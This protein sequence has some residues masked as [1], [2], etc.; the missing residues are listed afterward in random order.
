MIVFGSRFEHKAIPLCYYLGSESMNVRD[1]TIDGMSLSQSAESGALA[2]LAT[3]LLGGVDANQP[4]D[5]TTRETILHYAG[6]GGYD[7][8]VKFLLDNGASVNVQDSS[9]QTPLMWA[10]QR[11][12]IKAAEVLLAHGADMNI[13]CNYGKSCY[14]YAAHSPMLLY[15]LIHT[16]KSSLS[17]DHIEQQGIL[18]Y[19]CSKPGARFAALFLLEEL[20]ADPNYK[21]KNGTTALHIAA[22]TGDLDLLKALV[23]KG[24]DP[25]IVDDNGVVPAS[26]K[27]C[28]SHLRA[29][30]NS[31]KTAVSSTNRSR[32]GVNKEGLAIP[33]YSN[34][35][36]IKGTEVKHC[37]LAFLLP[38]II[39]MI[40]TQLPT[41]LGIL[42]MLITGVI[43]G[44]ASNFAMMQ[45]S[46]SMIVVGWVTGAFCFSTIPM[47]CIVFPAYLKAN[48]ESKL[49]ILFSFVTLLLFINYFYAAFTD[50]GC[51]QSTLVHRRG[52][53]EAMNSATKQEY[54]YTAMVRKP[55][56]SKHCSKT[57]QCVYR[58]DHYCLWIGNTV[59][60][61]NHRA[62]VWFCI[63][64]FFSHA[65]VSYITIYYYIYLAPAGAAPSFTIHEYLEKFC[66]VFDFIFGPVTTVVTFYLIIYN[67]LLFMF[68]S[69]VLG[70]QLWFILRNVTSNEVWF[71]DRYKWMMK[72][73][74]RAYSYYDLG[75]WKNLL[76]FFWTGDL[77]KEEYD[78]PP[79]SPYLNKNMDIYAGFQKQFHN[80]NVMQT[81]ETNVLY[82]QT[83]LSDQ[84]VAV[85]RQT[86]AV[87][88]LPY[89]KQQELSAV[90]VI[91]SQLIQGR[92]PQ[93]P[94]EIPE[95]RRGGVMKQAQDMTV[96][97]KQK[98]KD[99]QAQQQAE[100]AVS[101]LASAVFSKTD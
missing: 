42:S 51:V 41:V 29:F 26:Q 83:Y 3:F 94:D 16:G 84:G 43:F 27:Q 11:G 14:Y 72:L 80:A 33:N 65:I 92:D 18:H 96:I 70:S 99:L 91:F 100:A 61:G 30:L 73:G 45:K 1:V 19:C 54:D 40:G 87:T 85:S 52:A 98:M 37:L 32:N 49:V 97:Y 39:I 95:S 8:L 2:Q 77:C 90:Q 63:F 56:R 81:A 66:R 48:P 71:A 86:N 44:I 5:D 47:Y 13:T 60:G 15:T 55:N 78:L 101:T 17:K 38:N 21:D 4:L 53:Y 28:P 57:G 67:A 10:C 89:E 88:Q 36:R 59:G 64:L 22:T 34:W 79:L 23:G 50:P 93:C 69:V 7:V 46:R 74:T 6:R 75:P 82:P 31:Y 20:G 35:S 76:F 62:F 58:F 9:G 68:G 25:D 12:N 24:A